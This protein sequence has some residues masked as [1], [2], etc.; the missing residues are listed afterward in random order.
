MSTKAGTLK[1][2]AII[3]DMNI[4]IINFNSYKGR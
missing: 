2:K 3:S 4:L 1:K